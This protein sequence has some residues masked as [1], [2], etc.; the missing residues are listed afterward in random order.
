MWDLGIVCIVFNYLALQ[1]LSIPTLPPRLHTNCWQ[2]SK[3]NEE[4]YSKHSTNAVM[5][6]GL[7]L[8]NL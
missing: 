6:A 5:F 2:L 1:T 4:K 8:Q 7:V 3:G